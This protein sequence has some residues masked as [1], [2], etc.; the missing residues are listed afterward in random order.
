M[1]NFIHMKYPNDQT[2][3]HGPKVNMIITQPNVVKTIINHPFGNGCYDQ[4]LVIWGMVYSC[5]K[6]IIQ[7]ELLIDMSTTYYWIL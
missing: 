7:Y 3:E 4:F 5:F 6:Y 2:F 1:S